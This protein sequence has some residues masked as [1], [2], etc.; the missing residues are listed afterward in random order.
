M[1]DSLGGGEVGAELTRGIAQKWR[2]LTADERTRYEE[3][4]AKDKKRYALELIEWKQS[5]E[6]A[7]GAASTTAPLPNTGESEA[8]GGAASGAVARQHPFASASQ[9]H[10]TKRRSDHFHYFSQSLSDTFDERQHPATSNFM[11]LPSLPAH[12]RQPTSQQF[13]VGISADHTN[14]FMA[15]HQTP[16]PHISEELQYMTVF[17]EDSQSQIKDPS[18]RRFNYQREI[19]RVVNELG[20]DGVDLI[21]RLF[22]DG[23]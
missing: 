21:I 18:A 22:R 23:A 9:F 10:E 5:Q 8:S 6:P 17:R 11:E 2:L 14:Q 4:A 13:H 12:M 16:T 19:N 7:T 15:Q 3:M 1:K 20:D